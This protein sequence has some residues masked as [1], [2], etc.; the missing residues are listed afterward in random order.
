MTLIADVFLN[1]RTPKNVVT[2]MS[3]KSSNGSEDPSKSN[4][5][6]GPKHYLSHDDSTFTIFI[7]HSEGNS[8][9]KSLSS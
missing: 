4:M 3:K 5:L 1:F 8:V 6:N 9:G 7:D 2:K